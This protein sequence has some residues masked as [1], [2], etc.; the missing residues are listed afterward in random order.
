MARPFYAEVSGGIFHLT[1]R[2]NSRRKIFLDDAD[3]ASFL[4][5]LKNTARR[6]G[7]RCLSYCLMPNHFHLLVQT[8]KPTRAA[9]MRDLKSEYARMFHRR[10]GS[11]GALFKPRYKPQLVQDN[12]YLL[13]AALYVAKNPV[14]AGLVDDPADWKWSSFA[15]DHAFVDP[16]PILRVLSA[17]PTRALEDF[18]SLA[19]GDAPAFDPRVPIA[20]DRDFIERHAP[21]SR[22]ERHVLKEMWEQARP[23]LT[24][25]AAGRDELEFVRCARDM[26]RYTLAEIAAFLGCSVRTVRR[27]LAGAGT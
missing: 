20:G 27:R 10:Y 13:A 1:S 4:L 21:A 14:R 12:G 22:P 15:S 24:E 7:W 11:D 3:Y 23:P 19:R 6:H 2:G 25:V 9:G 18:R 16:A 8:S 26:H 17:D 5:C